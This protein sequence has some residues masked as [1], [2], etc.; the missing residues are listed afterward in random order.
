MKSK[1]TNIPDYRQIPVPTELLQIEIPSWEAVAQPLVQ[2]ALQQYEEQTGEYAN[3][4]TDEMVQTIGLPGIHRVHDLKQYG[5][6]LYSQTQKE[7][8]FYQAILPFLL[9]FYYKNTNTILNSDERDYYIEG[10]IE[11]VD[12]YAEDRGMSLDEYVTEELGLEGDAIEALEA[13]AKEDFTFKIISHSLYEESG[14]KLTEDAYEEYIHGRVLHE[15]ADEIELRE[16]LSYER[17]LDLMPQMTLS[18]ALY[19]YFYNEMEFIINP[20]MEL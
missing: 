9:E 11:K 17:F 16:T 8:R 7:Y 5:M 3:N 15:Q 13:Q 12:E 19:E 2:K 6:D 14:L 20:N 1:A 18:D 10:Y 4:L